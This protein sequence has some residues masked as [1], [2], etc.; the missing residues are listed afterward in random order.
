[1]VRI[2]IRFFEAPRME[3]SSN[4]VAREATEIWNLQM[5]LRAFIQ[6]FFGR[7]CGPDVFFNQGLS[8][9][10]CSAAIAIYTEAL[11]FF[12]SARN[13]GQAFLQAPHRQFDA[14]MNA[15]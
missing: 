3:P 5:H 4:H 13:A 9:A 11:C 12:V 7:C 14:I 8:C 10:D 15:Q 1:M 6:T 2:V